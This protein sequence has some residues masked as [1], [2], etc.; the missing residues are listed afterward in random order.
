MVHANQ[1]GNLRIYHVGSSVKHPTTLASLHELV[2]QYFKRHPWINKDGKP[3]IVGRVRVLD[4][5]ASFKGYLT[6]H[7]LVPLKALELAN[8]AFCQYFKGTLVEQRR[9]IN[10]I[11]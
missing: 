5:M 2:Y 8:I 4:S 7:Y 6:L 10:K 3:V 11:R 1:P 9:K